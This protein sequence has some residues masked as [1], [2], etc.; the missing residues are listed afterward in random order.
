MFFPENYNFGKLIQDMTGSI[1]EI[2]GLFDNLSKDFKDLEIYSK[3]SEVI[4]SQVDSVV[5]DFIYQLNTAF[6][7]PYD[8]EDL[9]LLVVEIDNIVDYIDEVFHMLSI[10]DIQNKPSFIDDFSSI[11]LQLSQSLQTLIIETF[12][13]KKDM[14]VVNKLVIGI[15]VLE[16][17]AD[18][19]YFASLRKIIMEEKDLI[20]VIK[21]KDILEKLETVADSYKHVWNTIENMLIK[22][23]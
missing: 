22:M 2:F 21:L 6:I 10:Y 7:T 11:Y 16:N 1:V 3:K 19:V 23:G 12:K 13:K 5:H 18:K 15:K 4:E 8:R 14:W 9:H 17:Q 20:E